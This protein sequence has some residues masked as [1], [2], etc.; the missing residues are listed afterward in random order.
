[1]KKEYCIIDIETTGGM[2]KRDR[3][4]E[5][6][7]VVSDGLRILDQYQSLINPGRSIPPEITRITGITDEMVADAPKFYEIAKDI[8]HLTE[9][10]IFIA[11]NVMFDYS[12]IREEFASLG[13]TFTRPLLCTVRLSRKVFP[14]LKSYSLG[15]LI[16]HFNIPVNDR[17]RAMEDTM[18]TVKIFHMIAQTNVLDDPEKWLKKQT[19][20]AKLPEFLPQNLI[21]E[22]P[23]APGV[24]FFYNEHRDII[25]IGK[26]INIKKRVVQHFSTVTGKMEKLIQK[27]RDISFELTG[28]ELVALLHENTLIKKHNPE[29]NKALRKKTFNTAIRYFYDNDKYLCFE[30][31][32]LNLADPSQIKFCKNS[33]HAHM[34]LK[35][36]QEAFS[37]CEQK[38]IHLGQRSHCFSYEIDKCFGACQQKEDSETYNKR[39]FEAKNSMMSLFE[40]DFL[41]QLPGRSMDEAAIVLVKDGYYRGFC[42]FDKYA[43]ISDPNELIQN[44]K[45]L[46][47]EP[48]GNQI[49]KQ[50]ISKHNLEI[51]SI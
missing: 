16:N 6:A 45:N 35:S 3:I 49:L 44:I 24:Y 14:G 33:Q 28:S 42:F 10:R 12:F 4:T 38:L 8:I 47:F 11:H 50:Y 48:E 13:Y 32:K 26:S 29:I 40:K 43:Q 25:Y 7:I 18:A 51:I 20:E 34:L 1:M 19:L 46:E 5:I 22:L 27:T 15:M 23:E 31:C 2:A 9:N 39:A 17:H 36:I 37:L 41:L 30:T 21:K